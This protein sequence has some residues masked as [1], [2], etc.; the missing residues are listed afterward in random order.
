[1]AYGR[2]S[3][4]NS[5]RYLF[6]GNENAL[7]IDNRLCVCLCMAES[8]PGSACPLELTDDVRRQAEMISLNADLFL[9]VAASIVRFLGP[10]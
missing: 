5:P 6:L 7:Y 9:I 2:Q 8:Q 1:M 3:T 10:C 4:A